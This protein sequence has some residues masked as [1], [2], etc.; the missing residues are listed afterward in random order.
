[1]VANVLHQ[2]SQVVPARQGAVDLV[3][4]ASGQFFEELFEVGVVPAGLVVS[5]PVPGAVDAQTAVFGAAGPV[6]GW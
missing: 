2:P 6:A 1:M 3:R 5:G 4:D